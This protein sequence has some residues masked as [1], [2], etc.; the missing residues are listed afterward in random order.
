MLIWVIDAGVTN[1]QIVWEAKTGNNISGLEFR[2]MLSRQLVNMHIDRKRSS[3]LLP[4]S[5]RHER[6]CRRQAAAESAPPTAVASRVLP[7]AAVIRP[8]TATQWREHCAMLCTR[9]L[10]CVYCSERA[11]AAVKSGL[12]KPKVALTKF[13]CNLCVRPVRFG[14]TA[15]V[16]LCIRPQPGLSS[17]FVMYHELKDRRVHLGA[18]ASATLAMEY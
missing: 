1:L 16:A 5:P 12:T 14:C 9:K 7:T 17:C 10:R 11:D 13:C 2:L 4:A 3:V 15:E 6:Y 18:S 8:V